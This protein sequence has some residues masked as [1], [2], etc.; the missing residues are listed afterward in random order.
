M[1]RDQ[2]LVVADG[3]FGLLTERGI[4]EFAEIFVAD[5]IGVVIVPAVG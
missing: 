5:E 4:L 1:Q 3:G 2:P